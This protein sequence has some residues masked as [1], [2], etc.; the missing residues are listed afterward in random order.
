MTEE[1]QERI[2]TFRKSKGPITRDDILFM[3]DTMAAV[4]QS[5]DGLTSAVTDGMSKI[6]TAANAAGVTAGNQAADTAAADTA[7]G[8]GGETNEYTCFNC[9]DVNDKA[10]PFCRKCHAGLKWK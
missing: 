1:N 8:D 3:L 2:D 4:K 5:V 6:V 7:A 10:L 9:G